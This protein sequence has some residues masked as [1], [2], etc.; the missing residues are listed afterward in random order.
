MAIS[1]SEDPDELEAVRIAERVIAN[2]SK[3]SS[4]RSDWDGGFDFSQVRIHNDATAAR[5]AQ[6]V[7]AFA[8]TAGNHVVFGGGR[9]SPQTHEGRRLLAHELVHVIQQSASGPPGLEGQRGQRMG[10]G[11]LQR[12]KAG[13]E[14]G[15]F[16]K[17]VKGFLTEPRR[18]QYAKDVV[19][20]VREAPDHAYEVLVGEV[21]EAIKQHYVKFFLVLG[22]FIGAEIVA[23]ILGAVPEPT[24]LTKVVA[25]AVQFLV[26]AIMGYYAAVELKGAL[27]EGSRFFDLCREANGNPEKIREA[28]I[29]LLRMVRHII[30]AILNIIGARA[31]LRSLGA[32]RGTTETTEAAEAGIEGAGH[33]A[34]SGPSNVIPITRATRTT[35]TGPAPSGGPVAFEGSLAR[36]M[37]TGPVEEPVPASVPVARTTPLEE[38]ASSPITEP[39]EMPVVAKPTAALPRPGILPKAAGVMGAAGAATKP[40]RQP[41]PPPRKKEQDCR[42]D[43]CPHPLSISWPR[44]LPRPE[45][46]VTLR[47]TPGDLRD[48]EALR[49]RGNVQRRFAARIRAAREEGRPPERPCFQDEYHM[50]ENAI[51]DA[52][53]I[54][55]LMLGGED[56]PGN[57]CALRHEYHERGHP[58]LNDQREHLD[59][60]LRCRICS[61]YLTAH[62]QEQEY[63]IIDEKG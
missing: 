41:K 54:Q 11:V 15:G 17:S 24:M 35:P 55:P 50:E 51:Y 27:E 28:S 8:F 18:R 13:E 40:G 10:L 22:G 49:D 7:G 29:A 58:Y 37:E 32:M 45:E 60:Y 4:P 23:G 59:E 52:H 36:N 26:F 21:L 6:A 38:P 5:S 48:T 20:A 16:F 43:P 12:Q 57:L 3:T 46:D 47:R 19:A 61:G 53:H 42:K 25:A 1:R 30:L 2:P 14:S 33:T 63:E 44:Q 31:K 9:Y 34:A 56:I 62:P 39:A